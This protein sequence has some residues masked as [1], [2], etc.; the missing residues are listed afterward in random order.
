M[1]T[2]I[3]KEIKAHQHMFEYIEGFEY[4][5]SKYKRKSIEE[6]QFLECVF[7]LFTPLAVKQLR[8]NKEIRIFNSGKRDIGIVFDQVTLSFDLTSIKVYKRDRNY[9]TVFH[10]MNTEIPI[11]EKFVY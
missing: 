1:K 9:Q 5:L 3:I 4:F 7:H 10:I 11:G 6:C 2:E 8:D